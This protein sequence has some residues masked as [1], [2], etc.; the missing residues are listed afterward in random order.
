MLVSKTNKNRFHLF[1]KKDK[2][3]VLFWSQKEIEWVV[4]WEAL[5]RSLRGIFSKY[6]HNIIGISCC[7]DVA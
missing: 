1:S 5:I 7:S 4:L 2:K 6:C 3:S